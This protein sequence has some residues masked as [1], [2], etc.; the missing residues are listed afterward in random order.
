[1]LT[2]L[3]NTLVIALGQNTTNVT[4]AIPL[5]IPLANEEG[6]EV[7]PPQEGRDATTSEA[8]TNTDA[9]RMSIQCRHHNA[10]RQGPK[11]EKPP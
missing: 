5:G 6:E 10:M 11:I 7:P 1:M 8:Q 3:V 2:E 4:P 9:R